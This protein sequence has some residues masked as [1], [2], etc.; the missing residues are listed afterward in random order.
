MLALRYIRVIKLVTAG[1]SNGEIAKLR[2]VT[3]HVVK[4]YLRDVYDLTGFHN[5]VELAIWW[6]KET[7][8]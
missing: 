6:I 3:L 7:E 5:R 4:N 2:G 8:F 1:L